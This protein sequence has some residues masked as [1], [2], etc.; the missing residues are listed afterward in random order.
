MFSLELQEGSAQP[1]D[2]EGQNESGAPVKTAEEKPNEPQQADSNVPKPSDSVD[3]A[4][5]E[6]EP[7]ETEESHKE[8]DDGVVDVSGILKDIDEFN[9]SAE[10]TPSESEATAGEEAMDVDEAP[11]ETS[12]PAVGEEGKEEEGPDTSQAIAALKSLESYDDVDSRN[13]NEPEQFSEDIVDE[14]KA[15]GGTANDKQA[16]TTDKQETSDTVERKEEVITAFSFVDK[17]HRCVEYVAFCCVLLCFTDIFLPA[18][19]TE[20]KTETV[21]QKQSE[22]AE[23]KDGVVDKTNDVKPEVL[24]HLF[25]M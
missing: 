12:K 19:Q 25:R 23:N 15:P 4:P 1:V 21:D 16:K 6:P 22:S 7:M 2:G 10:P 11:T 14:D 3:G 9:R 17:S 13:S 5:T 18:F 24:N 20:S 8:A